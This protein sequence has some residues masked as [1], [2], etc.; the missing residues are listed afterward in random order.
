MRRRSPNRT[1]PRIRAVDGALETDA[2]P[3][4]IPGGRLKQEDLLQAIEGRIK[5]QA[6]HPVVLAVAA[7]LSQRSRPR[8]CKTKPAGPARANRE[9]RRRDLERKPPPPLPALRNL[10]IANESLAKGLRGHMPAAPTKLTVLP[11]LTPQKHNAD[12]A[13]TKPTTPQPTPHRPRYQNTAMSR[14]APDR[15]PAQPSKR[16]GH[17]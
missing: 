16:N 9:R 12:V 4:R 11:A 15:S 7:R 6:V 5:P 2:Q 10:L 8:K 1:Q 14:P 3:T 13:A 17:H